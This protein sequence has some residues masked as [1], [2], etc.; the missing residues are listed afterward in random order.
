MKKSWQYKKFIKET[1]SRILLPLNALLIYL[2]H[3][4]NQY[5]VVVVY[6]PVLVLLSTDWYTPGLPADNPLHAVHSLYFGGSC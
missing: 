5:L 3:T 6:V 4:F 1:I 2:M